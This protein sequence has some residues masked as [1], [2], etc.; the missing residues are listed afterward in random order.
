MMTTPILI[1]VATALAAI[2][3]ASPLAEET[4]LEDFSSL[5]G[6]WEAQEANGISME[7]WLPP[8]D[9]KMLGVSQTTREGK[10]AWYE[11][12]RISKSEDGEI[13]FTASPSGQE[14]TSFRL[15]SFVNGQA[16]FENREHDF[17]QFI[18]YHIPDGDEL[19]AS[20]EGKV[21]GE[22]RS[23]DFVKHRTACD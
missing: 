18:I 17:P 13:T 4:R 9:D 3:R 2:P 19:R 8:S 23:V 10:T 20:I 1:L 5:A 6:C 21:D 16:V 11:Y 22:Q 12:M 7:H 14:I 15:V